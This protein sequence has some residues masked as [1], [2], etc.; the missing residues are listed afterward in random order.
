MKSD[1]YQD[2]RHKVKGKDASNRILF[3]VTRMLFD[4]LVNEVNRK[5]D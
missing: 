4:E 3:K 2:L 5:T 1:R